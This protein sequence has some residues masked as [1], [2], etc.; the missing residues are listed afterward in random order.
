MVSVQVDVPRL[1]TFCNIPQTTLN[2]L[3]NTPTT[4][5]VLDFLQH[6]SPRIREYDELKAGK[7]KLNVELENAVRGAESKNRVLKNSVDKRREEAN[8]LRQKL[9]EEGSCFSHRSIRAVSH[10]NVFRTSKDI[11]GL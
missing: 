6:L 4:D 9:Q 7:L 11:R 3:L 2:S 5:Q 10:Y 8:S 1:S